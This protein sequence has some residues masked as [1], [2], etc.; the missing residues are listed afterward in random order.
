MNG[1][2]HLAMQGL[3]NR[4][5]GYSATNPAARCSV[6]SVY[7]TGVGGLNP[8][9]QDGMLGPLSPPFPMVVVRRV[10]DCWPGG[11]DGQVCRAGPGFDCR[12][13]AGER[14]DTV[15]YGGGRCCSDVYNSRGLRKPTS[16]DSGEV[17]RALN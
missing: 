2:S 16:H 3:I 10:G 7:M 5:Q 4:G 15:D 9:I 14:T 1:D 6:V 11:C 12:S 17:E 13:H 8:Y